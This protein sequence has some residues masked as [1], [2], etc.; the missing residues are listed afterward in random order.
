MAKIGTPET[1]W[2][3]LAWLLLFSPAVMASDPATLTVTKAQHGREIALKVGSILEIELPGQGGTG[4]S[5]LEQA[6]GAP[7]LKLMDQTTRPDK[8][9]RL[10]GPVIQ[11]WRFKAVKPGTTEI[12]MAYYRAW[13]GVGTAKDH[14]LIK[15]H[16]E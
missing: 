8:Q 1:A 9:G 13:E 2:L 3:V 16:I 11:V 14:F 15:L 6:T 7:C 10:G 5:W 4:Y 12:K